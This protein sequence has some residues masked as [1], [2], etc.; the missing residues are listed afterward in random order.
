MRLPQSFNVMLIVS[1]A[2][3][4]HLVEGVPGQS[5]GR[6]SLF[7]CRKSL[8]PGQSCGG[9]Y[10]V[11]IASGD[12]DRSYLINIPP[13]YYSGKAAP[14]ILSYHGGT[15]NAT[16]QLQ[17]DQFTNPE[18]NDFAITVYPQG[19]NVCLLGRYSYISN[20]NFRRYGKEYQEPLQ[21]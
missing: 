5:C 1:I 21:V 17:L 11:S 2:L 10:N 16:E 18:F 19:I 14:V 3:F 6:P 8:P 15:R 9:T 7:G 20:S 12:L 4:A 13:R